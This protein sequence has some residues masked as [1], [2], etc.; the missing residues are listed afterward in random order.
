MSDHHRWH[1]AW[2]GTVGGPDHLYPNCAALANTTPWNGWGIV[3]DQYIENAGWPRRAI[4][5][6]D[7]LG[8][9]VCGLCVR[10]WKAK[11]P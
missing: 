10:R 2:M 11:Q 7:P 5:N 4:N 8:T 6:I 9:D 1:E 3:G